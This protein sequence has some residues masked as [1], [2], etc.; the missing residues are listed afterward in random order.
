MTTQEQNS[1]PTQVNVRVQ[2]R[3]SNIKSDLAWTDAATNVA[4][5]NLDNTTHPELVLWAGRVHF[6]N[7]PTPGEFRLVITEVEFISGS[8]NGSLEPKF[9]PPNRVIYSEIF[10]IDS[11]LIGY[12]K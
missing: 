10:E 9:D 4:T 12:P 3:I 11:A 8:T 5:V 6:A 2:Q 1:R 7:P